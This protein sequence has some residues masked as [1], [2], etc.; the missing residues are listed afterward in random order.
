MSATRPG[1]ESVAD[2]RTLPT[3]GTRDEARAYTPR[4]GAYG[5]VV[6]RDGL[7]AVVRSQDGCFLPGGGLESAETPEQAVVREGLEECGL[8]LGVGRCVTRAVQFSYS[9][10][11]RAWYEKRCW[12]FTTTTLGR[13]AER[14]LPGHEVLWLATADAIAALAHESQR[15]AV[16]QWTDESRAHVPA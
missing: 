1:T 15:W 8:L 12:F 14:Q 4:P 9:Q 2:W 10:E 6:D 5:F 11:D 13:H 3:F 7:L 16:G